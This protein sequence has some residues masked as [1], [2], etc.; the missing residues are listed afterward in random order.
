MA[1][2]LFVDDDDLV[3]ELSVRFFTMKKHNIDVAHNYKEAL[4]ILPSRDYDIIMID[5]NMPG[6][7]NGIDLLKVISEKKQDVKT[8][9]ITGYPTLDTATD[10]LRYGAFDYVLKP[11]DIN[12]LSSVVDK[13]LHEKKQTDE[14]Q[15]MSRA[16]EKYQGILEKTLM[17]QIHEIREVNTAARE[18]HVRSLQMLAKAAEYHD[19]AATLHVE[20]VGQ[21][22]YILAKNLGFEED[23]LDIILHAA[24]MH[25]VG[26]VGIPYQILIKPGK[27]TTAEFSLV[28]E[29]CVIGYEILKDEDH[30]Y[31]K[32]SAIIA[33]SHHEK[34]D[35]TGY[36]YQMNGRS[37]PVLGRIVAIADVYDA[38]MSR[39]VYKEAWPK[40][41]V[42]GLLKSEKGKHFDPE[43][44]Q[45]F[46]DS[47]DE[48]HTACRE[49]EV[50][51]VHN[52]HPE[53]TGLKEKLIQYHKYF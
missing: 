24:P 36:P 51:S 11:F 1:T 27:L 39:R 19:D 13:A 41:E 17:E 18:A 3:C 15:K 25:D 33:L 50:S 52:E 20:K 12:I 4:A 26:K 47:L 32:A 53:L 44:V 10:A 46:I 48:V 9:I 14:S 28:Q 2:I 21:Y 49:I 7:K 6:G 34:Y 16:F 42:V 30:P 38:L 22:S 29:H 43:M 45:C 37:I 8:I 23:E 5:I 31:H 40:D 35:G